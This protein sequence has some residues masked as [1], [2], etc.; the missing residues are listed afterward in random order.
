MTSPQSSGKGGP[1]RLVCEAEVTVG[2][3]SPHPEGADSASAPSKNWRDRAACRGMDTA[4]WFS[5]NRRD[6]AVAKRVCAVCPVA[7]DCLR[8]AREKRETHGIRAGLNVRE[9]RKALPLP[10]PQAQCG[11]DSGYYRHRDSGEDA[12]DDC[13]KA[14]AAKQRSVKLTPYQHARR[15]ERRR[16][17]A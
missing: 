17:S 13:K 7:D 2:S 16:V 4:L 8:D 9:Q 5:D 3:P 15:N 11:T 6:V 1:D 14:H 12:C 10:R